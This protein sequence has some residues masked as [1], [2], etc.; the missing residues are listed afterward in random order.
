VWH[1]SDDFVC[2]RGV[3]H[4]IPE[5]V[6]LVNLSWGEIAKC[7]FE[8]GQISVNVADQSDLHHF[9]SVDSL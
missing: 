1:P 4:E 3:T 6:Q 5:A 2:E 7:R 9:F 8:G